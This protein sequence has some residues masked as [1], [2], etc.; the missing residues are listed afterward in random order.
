MIP[1]RMPE[2]TPSSSSSPGGFGYFTAVAPMA[3]AAASPLSD[4]PDIRMPG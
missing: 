2:S 4:E 1:M 3:L